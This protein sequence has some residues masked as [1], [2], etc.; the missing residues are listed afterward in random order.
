MTDIGD[1]VTI[2]FEEEATVCARIESIEPDI[3][4][5][6][7]HVGLLFLEPPLPLQQASWILRDIYIMG[8]EF[9]MNG[10]RVRLEKIEPPRALRLV[11]AEEEEQNMPAPEG[12]ESGEEETTASGAEVIS[13]ADFRKR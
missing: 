1:I 3:K 13:L 8:Q 4:D 7:F 6:W 9:T 5:G 10:T 2:Y 11:E 12:A